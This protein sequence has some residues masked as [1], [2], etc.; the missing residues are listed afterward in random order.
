MDLYE[1]ATSRT[2][3]AH[4]W[5]EVIEKDARDG[6]I[7]PGVQHF[8]IDAD[9]RLDELSNQLRSGTFEPD[10]LTHVAIPKGDGDERQL[11]IPTVR[12]RI[13]ERAILRTLNPLIDPQLGPA[14]FAYRQGLGVTDAALALARLRDEGLTWVAR[15]DVSSC[16]PN[17]PRHHVRRSL[18][19][20]IGDDR[21]LKLL[22]ALI[23]RPLHG[24]SASPDTGLPQ[25]SVLSPI[26]A[27][28]VLRSVD[29]HVLRAGFPVI[30]YADD[31]VACAATE[32]EAWEAM[33]TIC[34]AVEEVGMKTGAEKAAIGSFAEGFAF[35][36]A[37]F[38]PQYP[39]AIDAVTPIPERKTLY[40]GLPGAGTRRR[41]GRIVVTD[42]AKQ[43]VLDV[44][45][46]EVARIVCFG[47]VGVSAGLR[48]WA[49]ASDV[50]IIHLS[51]SG[52][53]LGLTTSLTGDIRAAR[54]RN[55][56]AVGHSDDP[57]GV[58][59]RQA[60]VTGK[61]QHQINLLETLLRRDTSLEAVRGALAVVEGLVPH[62]HACT[63]RDTLLG[64]EGAAARAYFQGISASLPESVRFTQRSKR[65]PRDIANACLSYG[66][67]ILLGECVGAVTA[68]GLEPSLGVLHTDH[69]GRPSM[70][71]DLMEQFRP[72]VVDRAVV[73]AFRK[74]SLTIG[75]GQ[76]PDGRAG[77]NLT[78]E[79]RRRRNCQ[80]LWIGVS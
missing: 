21:I 17:L 52:N 14:A 69:G 28:L 64:L 22:D 44:P 4:A 27:N 1:R 50:D 45:S 23:S 55:Q 54:I 57:R 41:Q 2:A 29:R 43:D 13:V 49:L 10:A 46:A 30:R 6:T 71:L 48:S 66:Y 53:Y 40:V 35:L 20:T 68:A 26:L 73:D 56:L 12:D 11:D 76:P 9:S 42:A 79:G 60:I 33:R 8:T 58:I 80:D 72:L 51:R 59:L 31:L 16:F 25:G 18:H 39:P 63:D 38:G 70:A 61:I 74:G 36:G 7:A 19:A 78:A 15:A 67:A 32:A 77:V 5:L 75:H 34:A 37:T 47:P 3:L 24:Q 65:P 62:A